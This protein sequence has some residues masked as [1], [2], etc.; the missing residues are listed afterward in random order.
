ME[1][2]NVSYKW[3][4]I[5]DLPEDWEK[6][7]NAEL[8]S[9]ADVWKEQRTQ[10]TESRSV[11]E[12]NERLL[13]E[14][15]IETGI[16][17]RLYTI[18]RGITQLLIEQGIDAALIPDGATNIP[19]TELIAVIK[20][21]HEAME[22]LFD[23]VS[24]RRKLSLTYIR[25]L[26]QVIT[27][28]QKHV[29]GRDQFGNIVLMEIQRGMWKQR[30]NNPTRPDG[31]I[32][33]YCPPIHVQA[34]MEKIVE[35][36]NNHRR[37]PPEINA[38]WLHHRFTQIHPFQDGN[39][40]VARAL[41]TLVFLQEGWFPLV[42]NR[43]QR[44]EYIRALESADSGDLTSLV[45]LFGQIAKRSFSRALTLSEDVLQDEKAL[46]AVVEGIVDLYQSRRQ[47]T[48]KAFLE[49]EN[50]AVDLV[51]TAEQM[52]VEVSSALQKKFSD[53]SS[54][55]LLRVTKSRHYNEFYYTMQIIEVA[56][57][58][59]YWANVSRKR[60]WIRLHLFDQFSEQKAQI[61]FSFHYLGK[62]NRGIMVSTGFI[63]FPE[64]KPENQ[65]E[66]DSIEPQFGETHRVCTEPFYFSYKDSARNGG[67][68]E[69]YRKWLNDCLTVGL[70]EWARRL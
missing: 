13:R 61:V 52:L 33:E 40:R 53:V 5:T 1:E 34:E 68:K 28:N 23:F 16:L 39:G 38:A 8:Y 69:N 21:H 17:E 48:E 26:H 30:P 43:D 6:F 66:E 25:Q 27:R 49:V 44:G 54:P 67:L 45:A 35:L 47:E 58:L 31:L 57:E 65:K 60:M 32:H 18:D 64:N 4:S 55:P 3:R 59:D 22:G 56:R 50:L 41:A 42:I 2:V 29:E 46:P 24:K 12:F 11:K 63:F 7:Q 10:L 19:V 9:L 36:F 20:D 15:S 70:A 14:W 62:V 37:I 51:N